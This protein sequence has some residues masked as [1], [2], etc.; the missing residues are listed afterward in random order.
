MK[1][2]IKLFEVRDR[3]TFIPVFAISTKSS[4]KAQ[5]YLLWRAGFNGGDAV[6]LGNLNGERMS[7]AD[8]YAWKDRTM[9]T[10]HLHIEENFSSLKDGDVIDVEYILG[11]SNIP[12]V[13]EK[14]DSFVV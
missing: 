6:I 8:A 7:T 12:K 9:Q 11:E 3:M 13:S 10:A 4:D 2:E 1:V 14:L 5:S